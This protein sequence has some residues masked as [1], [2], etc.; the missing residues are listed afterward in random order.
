LS[1]EEDANFTSK[2]DTT[3]V[4]TDSQSG[5]ARCSTWVNNASAPSACM[6]LLGLVLVRVKRWQR[7]ENGLFYWHQICQK[8]FG[9][10]GSTLDP[11][12]KTHAPTDFLLRAGRKGGQGAVLPKPWIKNWNSWS[13]T[14][15]EALAF[16][17]IRGVNPYGT[18]G[19]CPPN[20]YEGGYPW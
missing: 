18:G 13:V 12:G 5:N 11:T 19:T 6:F 8:C 14:H 16:A 15:I 3:D 20:I 9:G 10:R 2:H 7:H 4:R 1:C 17:V